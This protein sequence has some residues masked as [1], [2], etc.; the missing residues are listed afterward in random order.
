MTP[1]Q[2]EQPGQTTSTLTIE[3]RQ[4]PT[5]TAWKQGTKKG[6]HACAPIEQK[7]PVFQ[8]KRK[9]HRKGIKNFSA[10][11]KIRWRISTGGTYTQGELATMADI[12]F[13][14]VPF[15]IAELRR[16]YG[17]LIRQAEPYAGR[18]IYWIETQAT[19]HTPGEI[20]A[21]PGFWKRF[22]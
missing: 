13:Y 6:T 5:Q 11:Q 16:R 22:Y 7:S 4:T 1:R 12:P 14:D 2:P 18:K 8:K 10:F 15:Y 19:W 20:M 9:L 3:T 21:T 17:L